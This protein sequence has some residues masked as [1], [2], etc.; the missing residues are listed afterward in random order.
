MLSCCLMLDPDEILPIIDQALASQIAA[1]EPGC[2]TAQEAELCR[3]FAHRVRSYGL[4]HLRDAQAAED[5]VQDVLLLVI[6]KLRAGEVREHDRIAS[7]ILG[8]CRMLARNEIRGDTRRRALLDRFNISIDD[9]EHPA[10]FQLDASRLAECMAKLSERA[11]TVTVL[12]FYAD[13][14]AAEIAE[15]MWVSA[16]NVRVMRHRALA[17]LQQCMGA[18]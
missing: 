10:H 5:L 11:R 15:E 13:R 14:S 3:R 17:A 1:A 2:A 4:R 6:Q 18:S 7:F 8:T 16:N 12:T 9:P